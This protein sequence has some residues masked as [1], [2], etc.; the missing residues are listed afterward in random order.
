MWYRAPWAATAASRLHGPWGPHTSGWH[1]LLPG[2]SWIHLPGESL[3]VLTAKWT[4]CSCKVLYGRQGVGGR[5][6][7]FIA[8]F[9]M[10]VAGLRRE[11]TEE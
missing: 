7:S 5:G 3:I 4:H 2:T 10:N 8:N 11:V 1:L 9:S 6:D